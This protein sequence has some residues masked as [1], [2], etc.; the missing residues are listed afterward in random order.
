MSDLFPFTASNGP[1]SGKPIDATA[2]PEVTHERFWSRVDITP[3]ESGCTPWTGARRPDGYGT[4]SVRGRTM[5]AHRVAYALAFGS[6]GAGE[7]LLHSCDNRGCVNPLH[8]R[9]GTQREN[10]RDRELRGRRK[11]PAGELNGNAS[12]DNA[13]A[14]ELRALAQS[15]IYTDVLVGEM[16]GVSRHVVR[17]IKLNRSY[18]LA[19]GG[20]V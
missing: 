4:F 7:L 8:L 9:V 5:V 2:L 17:R 14:E 13:T 15:G 16:F 19:E 3:Q 18:V 11:R 10:M 12:L 6:V 20:D 1:N